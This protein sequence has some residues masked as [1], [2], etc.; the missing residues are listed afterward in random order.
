[1]SGIQARLN[2][3]SAIINYKPSHSPLNFSETKPTDIFGSNVFSDK[4]MK[5]RLPK[6]VYKSLKK[7]IDFAEKLD[8]SLADVVANA[9]KDWAI[10]KGATHF[11]HVFYPLT[12]L[13][14]EKHDA[15]LV[16]DG[17][18]GAMAEFSGKMLIQGEPDAS[19]FP[20]GGLRATFE[21]RGYTAW[22]VTS[23]AYLLENPNGTF[24]CIPTAFVSWTGEALDKKTPLLRSQQALNKQ[25]KRVLSLFGVNTKLP[26]GS[27]AGPEQ[28]YFLVDRNF[29]FS[30]PDLLIAGRS[31]FGAPSAKGQE[32][33][34]QYFGVINRRV[35]SFMMEVERELFKLG[36]PVKTR[37]NEVA[38]AQFEIAPIYEQG[39]LATDHNQL[40]MTTLRSVAKRYGMICLLHE[41]PFA[42]I[43]GSGKH[44]NYSLGNAELGS[45]FDP[46]DN[47]HSNAQFL[48]FCAAAIRALHKYSALLR[49]TVASASND[50]RLGANEAPPAIMSAYLGEQLTDVFEQIKKGEVKG[51]KTKGIMH[52]GVDTLPPLPMDPGDR[53]RTSPFAFT[54]NRFEFRAV[55]SSH[56]IAGAQV[57]LNTMM[58]E[59]LDYVATELEKLGRVNK[60]QFNE[61]VQKLL[62]KMITEHGAIVFNGDGYS[63]A[64]HK[65]AAKRGL[66]NLKT[67]PEALPVLTSKEVVALFTK[68]GVLS[69]AEL[70]SRQEIY[71]EQYVKTVLT[72]AN[73]VIRMARTVIFP[74]AMRYQG[75]LAETCASLK[76]IGHDFKMATLE[77]VTTELRTM[78]TEVDK[79][80][81]LIAHEGGDTLAHAKYMCEKVLPAMLAVRGHADA[82]ES[83]VADDLWPLPSYQEM[84][85]I[86]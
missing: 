31:L 48:V 24:L 58:A 33:E 49:A 77:E 28:E 39:N 38:P 81:K 5:E 67:T 22:D 51:S 42:G 79:L 17:D 57:A 52:I 70:K 45:L 4:V 35:L 32:F 62:Q 72:E 85:F 23:P 41:K 13:T 74:A 20:S 53:N 16:P 40:V 71:L 50:H 80:E 10:E 69:E 3:I 21:A 15:F 30:R 25:A 54:G 65:E 47:P 27:F 82:L 11:T 19:S 43:N 66:P 6:H 73:L 61:G 55:G 26:V 75:Q 76:V 84:L 2:A 63:D 46:G 56:S 29:V 60:T 68:Y 9:M 14:A 18:G 1:M 83:V 8:A 86:R 59:S 36:V 12:G 64:W 37:H 34:D 7:T 78:Q 44:L